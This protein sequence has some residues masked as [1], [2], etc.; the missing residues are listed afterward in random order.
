MKIGYVRRYGKGADK[1]YTQRE[2][3]EKLGTGNLFVFFER[4]HLGEIW[5]EGGKIKFERELDDGRIRAY[6]VGRGVCRFYPNSD[7]P[8]DFSG[9]YFYPAKKLTNEEVFANNSLFEN[10]MVDLEFGANQE[11]DSKKVWN[12]LVDQGHLAE[13]YREK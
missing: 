4:I 12:W 5:S 13:E 10:C 11:S 8:A 2:I 6:F 3:V 7:E 9:G 1:P